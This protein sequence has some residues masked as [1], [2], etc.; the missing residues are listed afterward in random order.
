MKAN[1]FYFSDEI[2]SPSGEV[3]KM[4]SLLLKHLVSFLKLK[5][6]IALSVSI[7][8]DPTIWEINK[9]YRKID[10]PTDVISFAYD[11]TGDEK[12]EPVDDL[13][14]IVISLD[15]AIRQAKEFSHPV[16]REIAFLFIHGF[17]HLL[18][19]DHMKGKKEEEEMFSLQN[20]I[21]NSFKYQYQEV[22]K[23]G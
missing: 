8:D 22:K 14:E 23:H 12:N 15:T 5:K 3:S 10:R 19:Y 20:E 17:L 13:G 7:V 4:A 9:T 1:E 11:D 6:P 2:T 21:L 16:E 18:G